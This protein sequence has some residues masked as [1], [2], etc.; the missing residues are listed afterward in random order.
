MSEI[1]NAVGT[2]NDFIALGKE[3]A[4][5]P[6]LVLPQY[7]P[8]ARDLYELCQKLLKANERLSDW[9]HRFRYFDFRSSDAYSKSLDTI[10]EYK[11]M[12]NGPEF[13]QLKCSCADISNI[14]YRDISSKIAKWFSDQQK[15]EEATGIF[16]KLTNADAEMVRFVFD[17]VVKRIDDFLSKMENYV[18]TNNLDKAEECRLD[19][20]SDTN[21]IAQQLEKFSSDLS[22]LV[23]SFS[24]IARVPVT[25]SF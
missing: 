5:L 17:T 15:L 13:Q 1:K 3:I 20:K 8:A 9:L 2:L 19:F 22:D 25:L 6:A 16:T 24:K 7:Q 11:T 10:R 23:I 12:K 18:D 21:K 4:K 14:Y